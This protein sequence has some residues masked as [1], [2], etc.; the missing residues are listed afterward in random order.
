MVIYDFHVSFL[1]SRSPM[2]PVAQPVHFASLLWEMLLSRAR[3]NSAA[4]MAAF[5]IFTKG[6][7]RKKIIA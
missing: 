4:F 1:I 2:L 3:C 6:I 5:I 7:M